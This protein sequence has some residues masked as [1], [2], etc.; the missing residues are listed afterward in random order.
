MKTKKKRKNDP[1]KNVIVNKYC[2]NSNTNCN[3][4]DATAV[5]Q[6]TLNDKF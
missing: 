6:Q 4:N 3:Q 5:A 1:T 2:A